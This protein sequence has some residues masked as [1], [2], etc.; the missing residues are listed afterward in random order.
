M[1]S[2]ITEGLDLLGDT[3]AS[4]PSD[5]DVIY[6]YGYGFPRYR[7]GPMFHANTIGVEKIVSEIEEFSKLPNC[8]HWK[9]GNRLLKI[10]NGEINFI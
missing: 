7:G 10:K 8:D 2:L 4:R 9:I 6:S 3:I 1:V 5:I